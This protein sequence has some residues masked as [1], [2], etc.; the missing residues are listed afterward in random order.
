MVFEK[1]QIFFF[2]FFF[3]FQK[4]RSQKLSMLEEKQRQFWNLHWIP[5]KVT[6]SNFPFSSY[7]FF[8]K[9]FSWYF[10]RYAL[11]DFWPAIKKFRPENWKP[12]CITLCQIQC[13]FQNCLS[14][15]S[16]IDSFWLL[17][18]WRFKNT[19][20]RRGKYIA[21]QLS[22]IGKNNVTTQ[23]LTRWTYL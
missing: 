6:Q 18:F 17:L 4:N 5:H 16:S 12:L 13:K 19:F 1:S 15:S 11:L 7:L 22:L 2:F 3:N 21:M 8:Y 9:F 23:N 14:F 10:Q 20:Y